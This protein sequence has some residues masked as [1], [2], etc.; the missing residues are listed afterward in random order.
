MFQAVELWRHVENIWQGTW[1]L[2][3]RLQAPRPLCF[4]EL[5]IRTHRAKQ[6]SLHTAQSVVGQDVSDV[7]FEFRLQISLPVPRVGSRSLGRRG[8][9]NC[10]NLFE[11][12]VANLPDFASYFDIHQG[13]GAW[14]SANL[15]C[16]A[17]RYSA[18]YSQRSRQVA[19]L[20]WLS[21]LVHRYFH[22]IWCNMFIL[23]G[24]TNSEVCNL[25]C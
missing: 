6:T 4:K 3:W 10:E 24:M 19:W 15:C 22:V 17:H 12:L 2:H 25:L 18:K 13:S 21:V 8:W 7:R 14:P 1:R 16:R 5:F 20:G 11:N 9:L 23:L